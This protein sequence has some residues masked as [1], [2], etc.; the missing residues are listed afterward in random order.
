MEDDFDFAPSGSAEAENEG[1]EQLDP[2]QQ[3]Q[4]EPEQEEPDVE[5]SDPVSEIPAVPVSTTTMPRRTSS[6]MPM[7]IPVASEA[8]NKWKVENEKK[9]KQRDAEF[10]Q[11]KKDLAKK[12]EATLEKARTERAQTIA[13]NAKANRDAQAKAQAV[14][15]TK[16]T[17]GAP[18]SWQRVGQLVDLEKET[19]DRERMRLLLKGKVV[20]SK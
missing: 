10:A 8:T 15:N 12:A 7:P 1:F 11:S 2:D 3:A 5:E 13:K 20:E 9:I 14:A 18:V 17:P 6:D 19:T 16:A 4:Q